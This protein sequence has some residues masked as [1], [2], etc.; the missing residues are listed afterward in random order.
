M[1]R[2][3]TENSGQ[4]ATEAAEK[5]AVA[6]KET[7]ETVMQMGADATAESCRTAAAFGKEQF[8]VAR[9]TYDKAAAC[10][11]DN[12]N[13]MS[14]SAAA[15]VA[16][17]DAYCQGVVDYTTTAMAENMELMQR[18]LA[19]KTPQEFLDIQVESVNRSVNRVVAQS[20]KVNQIA[21]DTVTKA[22][23][24]VKTR[25]DDTVEVFVRPQAA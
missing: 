8:D 1:E 5:I 3:M 10:G 9:D 19:A 24:P 11:K 13:A 6:G 18:F 20:T 21:A 12:L 15:V 7:L 14:E 17:W 2:K 4:A 23:E 25:I 22:L 16:G